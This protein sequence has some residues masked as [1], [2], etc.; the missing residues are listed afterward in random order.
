MSKMKLTYFSVM[1][2]GL[3]PALCC[4]ERAPAVVSCRVAPASDP[5]SA[6]E[7][8]GLP[9]DG[10]KS[11]GVDLNKDWPK[12]KPTTPFGQLP[13]LEVD[14]L[15]IAQCGERTPR[16]LPAPPACRC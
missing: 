1:A 12:L 15:S 7:L 5:H 3:G 10:P 11:A 13:L 6:A 9:W 16:C 8:S 4:G 2:K 14:G